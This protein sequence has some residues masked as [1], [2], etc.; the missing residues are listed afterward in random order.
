ME[1]NREREGE[2]QQ[3]T[4]KTNKQTRTKTQENINKHAA[5]THIQQQQISMRKTR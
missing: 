1:K 5:Y 3:K 4:N 2:R